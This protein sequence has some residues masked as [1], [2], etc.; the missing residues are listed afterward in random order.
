MFRV[1]EGS[2]W[3]GETEK[4]W[5]G[6]VGDN[7]GIRGGGT[8]GWHLNLPQ[9]LTNV[10]LDLAHVCVGAGSGGVGCHDVVQG[11]EELRT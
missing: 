10:E 11:E 2:E 5:C 7:E 6:E 1:I 9:L 4:G 8:A 3:G